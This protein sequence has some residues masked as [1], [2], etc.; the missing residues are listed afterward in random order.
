[1]TTPQ[2]QPNSLQ[3]TL[4]SLKQSLGTLRQYLAELNLEHAAAKPNPLKAY[5]CDEYDRIGQNMRNSEQDLH[6]TIRAL[7][8]GATLQTVYPAGARVIPCTYGAHAQMLLRHVEYL[9]YEFHELS[10]DVHR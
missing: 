5:Y 8:Q 2:P 6:R 9:V 3:A 7:K 1:M 10:S 4:T